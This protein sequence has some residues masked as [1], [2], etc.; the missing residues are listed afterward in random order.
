[1]GNTS[2]IIFD[3]GNGWML[4]EDDYGHICSVNEGVQEE[5]FHNEGGVGCNLIN[6]VMDLFGEE[7]V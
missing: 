3:S 2:D 4:M 7:L 5:V 6:S 1:M